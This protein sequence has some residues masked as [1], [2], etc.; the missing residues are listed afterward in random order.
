MDRKGLLQA[1]VFST[2]YHSQCELLKAYFAEKHLSVIIR[3]ERLALST[4]VTA[5]LVNS[6]R[7]SQAKGPTKDESDEKAVRKAWERVITK[8][9]L[10]EV[11]WISER[12]G[13]T[14]EDF[15]RSKRILKQESTT[16]RR[17]VGNKREERVKKRGVVTE[18]VSPAERADGFVSRSRLLAHHALD[19]LIQEAA[20]AV[21]TQKFPQQLRRQRTLVDS[22]QKSR[23]FRSLSKSRSSTQRSPSALSPLQLKETSDES[24]AEDGAVYRSVQYR[25]LAEARFEMKVLR[26]RWGSRGEDD[27]NGESG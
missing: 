2:S 12:I 23:P 16:A 4:F 24:G 8:A 25:T 20:K 13:N 22:K 1:A 17:G 5:V 19:R 11:T 9:K 3:S 7:F 26:G 15:S 6:E 10:E 27:T 21:G 14:Q 18:P